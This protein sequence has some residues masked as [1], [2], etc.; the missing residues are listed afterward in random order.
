VSGGRAAPQET[1]GEIAHPLSLP[2]GRPSTYI[3]EQ[4]SCDDSAT[5]LTGCRAAW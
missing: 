2:G 3:A 4:D 5:P 1:V